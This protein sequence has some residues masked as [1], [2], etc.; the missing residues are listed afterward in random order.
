MVSQNPESLIKASQTKV[1]WKS[2]SKKTK[3]IEHKKRMFKS[4]RT[5]G[6]HK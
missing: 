1:K 6:K 2:Q 3:Q 4:N 5:K